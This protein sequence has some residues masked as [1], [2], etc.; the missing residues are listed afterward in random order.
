MYTP[1]DNVKQPLYVITPIFNAQRYKRRWKLYRDFQKQVRDAGAILITVEAAF[2]ERTY[3]L[4]DHA[5]VGD[6]EHSGEYK[7]FG[8]PHVPPSAAMPHTRL[9]QD[10]IKIRVNQQQEIWLKENLLNIGVQH[11]PEDAKYVAFVDSDLVFTRPDWVSETLHAL[12]HYDVVQM[13]SHAVNLS[14]SYEPLETCIGLGYCHVNGVPMKIDG[15]YY[16]AGTPGN[17]NAWHPGWA[18]AW[19]VESLSKVGGLIE[20]GILG[21]GDMHM[22]KSLIGREEES[23][24]LNL[25]DGYKN[26]VRTW[27]RRAHDHIKGNVGYVDGTIFHH[28]HGRIVNRN[29]HNR[30]K[31]LIKHRFD[32]DQDLK[33]DHRGIIMLTDKKPGL[34]DD[35][36]K[37]FRARDEDCIYVPEK[38]YKLVGPKP[39]FNP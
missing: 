26:R 38:E 11:L 23:I 16:H 39:G 2:G 19:R 31:L 22:A 36:R 4:D 15:S 24:N 29:Y 35:I 9:Q 34:R 3:A 1:K 7:S 30:W 28:W 27:A 5:P 33:K 14:P 17:P 10:Y 32:P 18:W 20:H 37:Y 6:L 8:P 13:F 12:Q 25:T 21:A